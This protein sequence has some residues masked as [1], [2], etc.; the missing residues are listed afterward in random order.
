MRKGRMRCFA[1]LTNS[2]AEVLR[3]GSRSTMMI[4]RIK[5]EIEAAAVL[6]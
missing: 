1:L 5:V 2:G 4:A 3:A 6:T